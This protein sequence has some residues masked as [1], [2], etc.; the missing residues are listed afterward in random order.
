MGYRYCL[1]GL[2]WVG[3][4]LSAR[5]ERVEFTLNLDPGK[6]SYKNIPVSVLVALPPSLGKH[7]QAKLVGDGVV[8]I[9][10]LT[11][12]GLATSNNKTGRDGKMSHELHFVITELK[13]NQPAQV[14]CIVDDQEGY[15]PIYGNFSWKD[16]PGEALELN[17]IDQ[18]GKVSSKKIRPVVKYMYKAY[19][20]STKANRDLTYKVFHH[21]Y[22]PSGDRL[23][24]NGGPTGL[25]PH[26]RGLMFGF[27]KCTLPTGKKVDTW[28]CT[29]ATHLLHDKMLHVEAQDIVARMLAG[30]QW[31]ADK[32]TTFALEE[33]ELT[34]FNVAGGTL[35][36]FVS[37]LETTGGTV[38]LD[39]DPQHAGFHF[40]AH[41]DVAASTKDK[42][43]Y[44]RPDG[45]GDFGE[46]GTRNWDPKSKKGPVNL[47]WDACSFVL[48]GKR[49]T[50]LYMNHPSNPGE[51]RWSERDYGRFGCYFEYELTEKNPLLV[52]YRVWLQ[53]GEMTVEE[54]NAMHQAFTAPP[55]VTV[56]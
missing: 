54:C 38:K 7:Q 34:V 10:Q 29:D 12:F 15:A 11:R 5:A 17:F 4:T 3:L 51:L 24:T 21:V 22:S 1:I 47:P 52:R 42:T 26:H 2:I 32:K 36:E 40:R 46:K 25:Y 53:E 23:V 8:P 37:R 33:R 56:K 9:G 41:N 30:V 35:T 18:F 28:H 19:D 27:Y 44:L 20:D 48:D 39:G 55:K 31:N 6:Q 13:A 16:Q 14:K 49:Y 50:V 43:Y 45:K